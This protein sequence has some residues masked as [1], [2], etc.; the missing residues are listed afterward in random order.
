MQPTERV[1]P[2]DRE[3]AELLALYSEVVQD[4]RDVKARQW[5]TTT[6]VVLLHAATITYIDMTDAYPSLRMKWVLTAVSVILI[7]YGSVVVVHDLWA[8]SGNRMRLARIK[9]KY[10]GDAFRECWEMYV[11]PDFTQPMR[12]WRTIVPMVLV[13]AGASAFLLSQLWQ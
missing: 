1:A 13:M 7:D 10:F 11:K 6:Y 3:H 5:A 8:L 12:D 2:N 9:D 4:I